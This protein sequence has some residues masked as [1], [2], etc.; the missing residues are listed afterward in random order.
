MKKIV[1]LLIVVLLLITCTHQKPRSSRVDKYIR[2]TENNIKNDKYDLA[3]ENVKKALKSS[4]NAEQEKEINILLAILNEKREEDKESKK[5]VVGKANQERLERLKREEQE[6]LAKEKET[7]REQHG[8]VELINFRMECLGEDFS[9]N[10]KPYGSH[11]RFYPGFRNNSDSTIV[12]IKYDIRFLDGFGDLLHKE[13]IKE[14]LRLE[15]WKESAIGKYWYWE[16]NEFIHG[17]PYDK[18]WAAISS[19][20]I[21]IR[22][23]FKKIALDDGSSMTLAN[24]WVN[25]IA[26]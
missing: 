8:I 14:H 2:L 24:K 9:R 25:V 22:V 6:K 11:V 10:D 20:T 26:K 21:K 15:P 16:D 3:W 17:E 19:N 23:K 1:L 18:L 12:G 13:S 4:P 5:R 7:R